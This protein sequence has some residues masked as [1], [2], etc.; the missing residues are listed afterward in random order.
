MVQKNGSLSMDV[1]DLRD[2]LLK[3]MKKESAL[4]AD[5]G[6][7][8]ANYNRLLENLRVQSSILLKDQRS[9]EC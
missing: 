4:I 8:K 2:Y 7:H 9:N 6:A 3:A 1:R 5:N